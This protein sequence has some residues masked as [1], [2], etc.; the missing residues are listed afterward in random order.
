MEKIGL[1]K[2]SKIL[3]EI[4]IFNLNNLYINKALGFREIL[5]LTVRC[6]YQIVTLCAVVNYLQ[7]E[8][9]LYIGCAIFG[10]LV[11]YHAPTYQS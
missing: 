10:A 4:Y 2:W 8:T 9:H 3:Y 7:I 5:K 1:L 6:R 11:T